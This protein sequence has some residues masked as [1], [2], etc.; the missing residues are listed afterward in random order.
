MMLRELLGKLGLVSVLLTEVL[1]SLDHGLEGTLDLGP[2]AGL[3]AA[4]GVDPELL[5][6]DCF[7]SVHIILGR[8]RFLDL[9]NSSISEMRWMNSSSRGTRGLWMS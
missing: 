2:L 5:R 8:N 6:A 3:Q 9:R 4:V 7:R 1:G